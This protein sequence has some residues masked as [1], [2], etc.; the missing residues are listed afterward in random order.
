M[1]QI[2]NPIKTPK[3]WSGTGVTGAGGLLT[4]NFPTAFPTAP[5]V[6]ATAVTGSDSLTDLHIHSVSNTAVTL[7]CRQAA[8]IILLGIQLLSFPSNAVGV[9]VHVHAI[10]A[11]DFV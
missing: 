3:I 6:T 9:T 10:E 5:V 7:H 11:G 2:F 4:I 8:A 1:S